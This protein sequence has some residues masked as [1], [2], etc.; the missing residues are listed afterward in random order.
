[1]STSNNFG[2]LLFV[3]ILSAQIADLFVQLHVFVVG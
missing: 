3:N 1:M 2:D